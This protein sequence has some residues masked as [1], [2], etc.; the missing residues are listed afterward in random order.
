[1]LIKNSDPSGCPSL[2][3]NKMGSD[4]IVYRSEN[5]NEQLYFE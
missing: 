5:L 4:R 1:M 2:V 3:L